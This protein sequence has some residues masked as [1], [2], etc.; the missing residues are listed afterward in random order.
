MAFEKRLF[1]A[2]KRRMASGDHCLDMRVKVDTRAGWTSESIVV[3]SRKKLIWISVRTDRCVAWIT[4]SVRQDSLHF[5]V[6]RKVRQGLEDMV[7]EME[8]WHQAT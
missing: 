6:W 4:Y 3:I 1:G 5:L 2:F 8:I 7:E